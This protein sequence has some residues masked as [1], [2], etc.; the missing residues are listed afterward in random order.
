MI[1]S[2]SQFSRLLSYFQRLE[3]KVL[4]SIIGHR[5]EHTLQ[6]SIRGDYWAT[7]I[8]SIGIYALL[9]SRCTPRCYCYGNGS[10]PRD[11]SYEY[12]S[13]TP[14]AGFIY[15]YPPETSMPYWSAD[16][17][18]LKMPHITKG[19]PPQYMVAHGIM[20][21]LP[22][23]ALTYCSLYIC[24][25]IFGFHDEAYCVAITPPAAAFSCLLYARLKAF[26]ECNEVDDG[27]VII[28]IQA[29]T[30]YYT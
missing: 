26:P 1:S 13:F 20:R 17:S 18:H 19:R 25:C 9:L 3:Y 22:H 4:R 15:D 11:I 6:C 5:T 16:S 8:L 23:F 28:L 12:H 7:Y 24:Y 27:L 2:A 10:L 21:L 29:A 14:S 30:N